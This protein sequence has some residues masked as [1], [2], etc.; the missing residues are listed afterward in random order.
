MLPGFR[1][2]SMAEETG[3]GGV[4]EAVLSAVSAAAAAAKEGG[5]GAR[6]GES[7]NT[8]GLKYR[9]G[10]RPSIA[11]SDMHEEGGG[12]EGVATSLAAVTE[13]EGEAEK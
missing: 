12:G 13:D 11:V 7:S 5:G 10:F 6:P 4:E 8:R 9:K 1:K 3:A 2:H